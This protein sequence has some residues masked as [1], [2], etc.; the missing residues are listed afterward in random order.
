ML[1]TKRLV[2]DTMVTVILLRIYPFQLAIND[3]YKLNHKLLR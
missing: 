1:F 2:I 3:S